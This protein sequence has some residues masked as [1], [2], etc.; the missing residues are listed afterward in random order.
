MRIFL[1]HTKKKR[2][3]DENMRIAPKSA[4]DKPTQNMRFAPKSADVCVSPLKM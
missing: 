1:G 2:R 4:D 3:L